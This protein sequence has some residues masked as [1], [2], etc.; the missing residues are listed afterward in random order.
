VASL[1]GGGEA[2]LSGRCLVRHVVAAAEEGVG[3]VCAETERRW[4]ATHS[5]GAARISAPNF[6]PLRGSRRFSACGAAPRMDTCNESSPAC[7]ALLERV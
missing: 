6:R 3:I 4:L 1:A 7:Q 2:G 5:A